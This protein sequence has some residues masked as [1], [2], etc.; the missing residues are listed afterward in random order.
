MPFTPVLKSTG[1]RIVIDNPV[2]E[3]D[4]EDKKA[5]RAWYGVVRDADT[6]KRYSVYGKQCGLKCACD[7][8]VVPVVDAR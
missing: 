5:V 1:K 8:Y 7:A 2:F 6:G 3:A 4:Y